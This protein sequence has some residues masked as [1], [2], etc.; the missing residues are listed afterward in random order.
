MCDF[1]ICDFAILLLAHK[2]LYYRASQITSHKSQFAI[3][4][5][6]IATVLPDYPAD[7]V[8]QLPLVSSER[9]QAGKGQQGVRGET[10]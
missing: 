4:K 5:S 1:A 10:S 7:T 8:I 6:Q 9:C 3:R 2:A